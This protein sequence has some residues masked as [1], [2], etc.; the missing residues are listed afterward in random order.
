MAPLVR[1]KVI[2]TNMAPPIDLPAHINS[3]LGITDPIEVD[4]LTEKV[5]QSREQLAAFGLVDEDVVR[6]LAGEHLAEGDTTVDFAQRDIA[7][8]QSSSDEGLGDRRPTG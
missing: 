7:D 4:A 8:I 1:F 2:G 3:L 6:I 5:E